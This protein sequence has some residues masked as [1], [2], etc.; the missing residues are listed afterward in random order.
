MVLIETF[1]QSEIYSVSIISLKYQQI[2]SF[3]DWTNPR[4]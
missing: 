1:L 3:G 4:R 2:S